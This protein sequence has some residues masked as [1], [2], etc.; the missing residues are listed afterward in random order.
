VFCGNPTSL[1][2][3]LLP[4]MSLEANYFSYFFI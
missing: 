4:S 2:Q 3:K 1:T